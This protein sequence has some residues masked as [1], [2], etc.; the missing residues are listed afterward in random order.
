MPVSTPDILAARPPRNIVDPQRPYAF[1]VE[2]ECD[3]RRRVVDVATV[4]LTNRECPFRC[5]MCDL[6]KNT[7]RERVPPG[8]IP[9]QIDYALARLGPARQIKLY[10][11]GNFFDPQAIPRADY[12]AIAS[13]LRDF[14]RVIVE[15]HP[16]LCSDH[17]LRFQQLLAA[18][19]EIA[20]GL[21]TVHTAALRAL[22]KQMTLEDFA[23]AVELLTSH[24]IAVRAFVLLNPPLVPPGAG[25][26][27]A[28]RSVEYAFSL[29]ATCCSIIATR[30]G[31][32]IM[33]RLEREGLFRQ[34]ALEELE[35]ALADG[36]A[37]GRGRAFVDL[38]DV[39]RL[40]RCN[41]CGPARLERLRQMN[42][43]QQV[44]PD[45]PCSCRQRPAE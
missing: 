9:R 5:L 36:L 44:L 4:F 26:Q 3:D 22:N 10:N 28:V 39:A 32:G 25:V 37:L 12:P 23:R 31:N 29:G 11:S 7:L 14:E 19:L 18:P 6:W 30:P 38:W 21:E 27:W 13:R 41:R 42:L 33:E 40:V 2:P 8:A 16:R 34:P 43:T 17:C 1:L 35:Q 45:V 20:L 15:N 24:D